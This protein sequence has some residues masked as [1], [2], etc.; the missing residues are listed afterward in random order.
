MPPPPMPLL[1]RARARAQNPSAPKEGAFT[2]TNTAGSF[3]NTDSRSVEPT[4]PNGQVGFATYARP[5]NA[6]S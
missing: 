2:T 5:G 6:G 4:S 3:P 1:T